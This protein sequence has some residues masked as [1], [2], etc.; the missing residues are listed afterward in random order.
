M[1]HVLAEAVRSTSS[2][3][4]GSRQRILRCNSAAYGGSAH[5]EQK[6][7]R[8]FLDVGNHAVKHVISAHLVFHQRVTL[9]IRLQA[10]PLAKLIHIIDAAAYW[11]ARACGT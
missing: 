5:M 3:A 8:L 9:T 1:I 10:D 7:H 2:A 11:M 4:A 6:A